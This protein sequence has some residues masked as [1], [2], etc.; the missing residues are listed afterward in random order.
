MAAIFIASGGRVPLPVLIS[1]EDE[2]VSWQ[3]KNHHPVKPSHSNNTSASHP[4]DLTYKRAICA[5]KV[6][7]ARDLKV[8]PWQA[9]YVM[10][11]VAQKSLRICLQY[12]TILALPMAWV[13]FKPTYAPVYAVCPI[14]DSSC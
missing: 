12:S 13:R 7:V 6:G 4:S 9:K 5:A 1:S 14:E 2:S 11:V 8:S 10:L 3:A